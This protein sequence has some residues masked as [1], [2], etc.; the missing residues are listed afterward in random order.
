MFL[1]LWVLKKKRKPTFVPSK[2]I[3][4]RITACEGLSDGSFLA[5]IPSPLRLS[6]PLHFFDFQPV[7]LEDV[8]RFSRGL[9]SLVTTAIHGT[10][11][12]TRSASFCEYFYSCCVSVCMSEHLE[13]ICNSCL[14]L[15]GFKLVCFASHV[16][17]Y[18]WSD[19]TCVFALQ[20][21][22]AFYCCDAH[23]TLSLPIR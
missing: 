20:T 3:I 1:F 6:T 12:L 2:W 9:R 18:A 23:L 4:I 17:W 10:L 13:W 19:R 5:G 15:K 14:G 8:L 11:F 16:T 7:I 21:I 22:W